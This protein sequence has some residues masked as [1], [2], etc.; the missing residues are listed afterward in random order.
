MNCV[1]LQNPPYGRWNLRV[2]TG[3]MSYCRW[4]VR[5]PG[6]ARTHEREGGERQI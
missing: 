4:G 3:E 1:L 2:V 5:L 6:R